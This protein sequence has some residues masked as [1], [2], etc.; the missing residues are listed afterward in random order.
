M[1]SHISVIHKSGSNFIVEKA[2]GFIHNLADCP[3]LLP[4]K[5]EKIKRKA[6]SPMALIQ[7]KQMRFEQRTS[8]NW[9]H[10][11]VFSSETEIN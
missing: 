6:S 1:T 10:L 4:V 2:G 11:S 7:L 8:D 5:R 3:E 9:L